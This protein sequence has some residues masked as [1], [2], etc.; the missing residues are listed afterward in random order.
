MKRLMSIFLLML[1][2]ISS[3]VSCQYF[4]Y[5]TPKS[6]LQELPEEKRALKTDELIEYM[7]EIVGIRN[8]YSTSGYSVLRDTDAGDSFYK[9]S[10]YEYE[11]LVV[12]EKRDDACEEL[13][14]YYQSIDGDSDGG[15]QK[16]SAVEYLLLQ[17][18]YSEN[19]TKS[20]EQRYAELME[21]KMTKYPRYI[22]LTKEE[23]PTPRAYWKTLSESDK[24]LGTDKLVEYMFEIDELKNMYAGFMFLSSHPTPEYYYKSKRRDYEV[25]VALEKRADVCEQLLNYY[26]SIDGEYSE[27]KHTLYSIE[28][29]LYQ[30]IYSDKMTRAEKRR[31]E[32][33]KEAKAD[34][35][36]EYESY[37]E[38]LDARLFNK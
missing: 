34:K 21:E 10:R 28:Y 2:C 14:N 18:I 33:L 6:Y 37:D 29:L 15:F 3:V 30:S 25:L 5:P 16:M 17:H 31:Y 35:Y 27:I 36:S 19:M 1:I 32:Q 9:S 23:Y 22:P 11:A 7:F 26:E 8:M 12:L 4:Q 24:S 38:Y 20:Q 13:L